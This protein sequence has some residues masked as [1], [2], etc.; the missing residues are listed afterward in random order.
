MIVVNLKKSRRILS[1]ALL[2]FVAIV[3]V[4][5]NFNVLNDHASMKLF[6][7][8]TVIVSDKRFQADLSLKRLSRRLSQ[9]KDPPQDTK[10]PP[11]D[12]KFPSS[13]K[14]DAPKELTIPFCT[15]K[16]SNTT[17]G[18]IIVNQSTEAKHFHNFAQA[19]EEQ[20]Y[21]PLCPEHS[22]L[23]RGRTDVYQGNITWEQ[24]Q[25]NK[26]VRFSPL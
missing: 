15:W 19:Y 2:A 10:D 8:A 13:D 12:T 1:V 16:D 7:A 11:Q 9:E 6:P 4:I 5:V 22:P 20:Q 17:V 21:L 24:A 26:T 14:K 3:I 23:L 18:D 25:V